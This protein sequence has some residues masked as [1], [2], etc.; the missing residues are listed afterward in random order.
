MELRRVRKTGQFDRCR[1]DIEGPDWVFVN[2][3]AGNSAGVADEEGDTK[4]MPELVIA[5]CDR[6]PWLR[7]FISKISKEKPGGSDHRTEERER[8]SDADT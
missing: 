8:S 5:A 6:P 4:S 7:S 3:V 1:R 2:L